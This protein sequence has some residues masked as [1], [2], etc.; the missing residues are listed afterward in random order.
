MKRLTMILAALALAAC[1]GT[2][3]A[4]PTGTP[5]SDATSTPGGAVP[6][7]T[8]APTA[9]SFKAI[10]LTGKGDKV[11]KFTIPTDSAAL[12]TATYK[13]GANFAIETLA[14]DGSQNGLL[15]NT[16]GAYSGTTLFDANAGEHSV[17]FKVTASAAWTIVV[18]PITAA[19]VW[20]TRAKLTGKGDD[21]V[22]VSPPPS[23]LATID[24]AGT[25]SENFVVQSY[26]PN[27]QDLLVNEIGKYSGSVQLPD[28]AFLLTVE[29]NGAW[30]IALEP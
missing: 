9:V 16:I 30:T 14:A 23:G 19:R 12:A 15:V 26:G 1:S 2:N 4:A 27:G 10:T 21:V 17:A 20:T 25:G 24:V 6:T 8:P 7:D 18:K 13:G 11:V 29:S 22:Q 5:G 3:V 28:G